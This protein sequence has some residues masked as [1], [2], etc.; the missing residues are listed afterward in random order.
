MDDRQVAKII[1]NKMMKISKSSTQGIFAKRIGIKGASV[2]G[3][4]ARGKIPE[5]W[6]DFIEKNYN[7]TRADLLKALPQER[8]VTVAGIF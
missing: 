2:S 1:L 5:S 7:V 4:I 3:A 6:F 8:S